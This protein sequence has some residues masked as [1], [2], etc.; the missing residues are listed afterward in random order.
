M[1]YG[2]V[3]LGIN[4][5]DVGGKRLQDVKYSILCKTNHII[6]LTLDILFLVFSIYNTVLLQIVR[7]KY[8]LFYKLFSVFLSQQF[9]FT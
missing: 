3:L 2:D 5:D 9:Y 6:Q 4:G 8:R 7:L 1:N